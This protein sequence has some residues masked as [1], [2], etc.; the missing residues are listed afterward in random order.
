[1]IFT[2]RQLN[3]I[4]KAFHF[5]RRQMDV[6]S[7]IAEGLENDRICKKL[8]MKYNTLAAHL[9]NIRSKLG[10]KGKFGIVVKLIELV[11]KHKI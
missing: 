3:F 7:C 10:V 2:K 6:I 5:T 8:G 4:Q 11:Q 9:W 1:M